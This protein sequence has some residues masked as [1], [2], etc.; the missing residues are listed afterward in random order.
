VRS[1]FNIVDNQLA[2]LQK[3]AIHSV[4]WTTLQTAFAAILNSL[5]LVVKA[6]FLSPQEFGYIAV[7]LIVIGLF[8]VIE[9]LGISQ[10]IIQ[11][12]E[13]SMQERSSLFFF[14]IILAFFMMATINIAAPFI[15]RF[16]SLPDLKV[17]LPVAG[18]IFLVTSPCLL[19]KAF[20]QKKMH[21]KQLSLIEILKNLTVLAL[22]TLFLLWGFG[23]M[24]VVYGQI[25]GA[26]F[27]LISI[28]VV[29][30]RLKTTSISFYFSPMKLIPFL[31]FG[32]FVSTKQL[33]TFASHRL[34]EIV[35]GYFLA[36]E[37]LGIYHFGKGLLERIRGLIT[38][39]FGAVLFPV[40]SQ[41]KHDRARLTRAYQLISRYIAFV[42]FPVFAG[43][44][45]TAHLFVPLFFGKQWTDSIIVFQ[46]FSVTMIFLALT[47]NVSSSLLYAVNKP[48]QVFY[49]DLITNG[50]YFLSLLLFAAQGMIAVLLVYSLYV[51]YKTLTLQFFANRQILG[52]F[53]HYFHQLASPA[54]AAAVMAVSVMAFQSLSRQITGNLIHL[55]ASIVIGVVVYGIVAWRFAPQTLKELKSAFLKGEIT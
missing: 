46:L 42:A 17:Y 3:Q 45:V 39:S 49:I 47:A 38:A 51:I 4:K 43:L 25:S 13:I 11:R 16:F 26:V 6:R 52:G 36:P 14:N 33:M 30:V 9:N 1:L 23:V 29:T 21:F 18:T 41:I 7:I 32:F 37:V 44:A 8:H 22:T 12:D 20:L 2:S 31:R 55:G 48:D 40:L 27:M 34:D 54:A 5:L 53:F 10:A 50:L 35:I 28:L 19:F 15:A 24:G